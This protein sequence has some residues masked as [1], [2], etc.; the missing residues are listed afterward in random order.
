MASET[1]TRSL[2][3]IE[4]E[5]RKWVLDAKVARYDARSRRSHD[6]HG[7]ADGVAIDPTRQHLIY[8]QWTST[9]NFAARKR[10]IEQSAWGRML[11]QLPCV[12]VLVWGWRDDGTLREAAFTASGEWE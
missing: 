6:L 9:A 2:S 5:R 7:I 4:C 12:R 8:L 1:F 10:K 11:V 3:R